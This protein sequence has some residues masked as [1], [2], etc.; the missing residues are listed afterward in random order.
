MHGRAM[1]LGNHPFCSA[2]SCVQRQLRKFL[3]NCP[4]PGRPGL[5]MSAGHKH[6]RRQSTLPGGLLWFFRSAQNVSGMESLARALARRARVSRRA[7]LSTNMAQAHTSSPGHGPKKR[8]S[9]VPQYLQFP[10][11]A[12]KLWNKGRNC[13][14]PERQERPARHPPTRAQV[15]CTSFLFL[16]CLGGFQLVNARARSVKYSGDP[17]SPGLAWFNYSSKT[18]SWLESKTWSCFVQWMWPPLWRRGW[19]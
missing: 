16:I 1:K 5:H 9:S 2:A 4:R 14:R 15:L 8:L 3:Q 6:I 10:E 11:N 18:W 19:A 12:S 13:H 17:L 7:L